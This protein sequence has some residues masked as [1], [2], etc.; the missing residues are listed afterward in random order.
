MTDPVNWYRRPG[1][2]PPGEVVIFDLDG[3]MS[4]A[5]PRQVHLRGGAPDWDAFFGAGIHDEPL[6]AGVTLARLVTLPIVVLSARPNFVHADTVEW[7]KKHRVP[8]DL[9][10]TRPRSDTR[11]SAAFKRAEVEL[12]RTAGFVITLAVDDD[13]SNVE[14]YRS[15]DVETIYVYSGYYDINLD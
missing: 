2:A 6:D 14:M 13:P 11:S 3:V 1:A 8:F 12:L 10:I 15:C 9:V 5:S 7:L 4:D